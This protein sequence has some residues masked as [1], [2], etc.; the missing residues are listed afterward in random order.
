MRT[1]E[2]DAQG[3]RQQRQRLHI[4]KPLRMHLTIDEIQYAMI[5]RIHGWFRYLARWSR[6]RWYRP[7][8]LSIPHTLG[9]LSALFGNCVKHGLCI[10][11]R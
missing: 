3:I 8:Y 2:V 7:W 10:I 1:C 6:L 4:H 5:P 11:S 9:G